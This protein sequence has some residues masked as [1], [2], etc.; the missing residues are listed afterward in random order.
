MCMKRG[1]AQDISFPGHD[2]DIS[3][4]STFKCVLKK[5]GEHK[6]IVGRRCFRSIRY[7]RKISE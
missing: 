6:N 4:K 7:L 2:I 5:C 1:A 3:R